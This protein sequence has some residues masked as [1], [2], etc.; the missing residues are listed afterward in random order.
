MRTL[1][2]ILLGGTL[3]AAAGI[4][5]AGATTP[6]HAAHTTSQ[7]APADA[8]EP[9]SFAAQNVSLALLSSSWSRTNDA[10]IHGLI[11]CSDNQH[12]D[13]YLGGIGVA[14]ARLDLKSLD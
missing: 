9:Y 1:K 14:G 11:I 7:T 3:F 10:Q 5:L 12:S 4:T 6:V 8:R 2:R 13:W